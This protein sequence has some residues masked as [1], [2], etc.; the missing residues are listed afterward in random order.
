MTF[1][2]CD[3]LPIK[4]ITKENYAEHWQDLLSAVKTSSF[5]ALDIE[6]SGLGDRKNLTLQ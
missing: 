6:M 1:V 4:D 2:T 5:I 3:N